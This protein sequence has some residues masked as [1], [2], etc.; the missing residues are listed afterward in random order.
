MYLGIYNFFVCLFSL[1]FLS[2][3]RPVLFSDRGGLSGV[4]LLGVGKVGAMDQVVFL[5]VCSLRICGLL[6]LLAHSPAGARAAEPDTLV[7]LL[8][9]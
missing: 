3:Q 5:H 1:L 6:P 8:G 4:V 9:G 2:S 7:I